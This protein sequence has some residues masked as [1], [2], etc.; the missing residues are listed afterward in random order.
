MQNITELR[1]QLASTHAK[2]LDGSMDLKTAKEL[3]NV[4]GKMIKSLSVELEYNKYLGL[5]KVIPFAT[6]GNENLDKK[7]M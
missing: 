2:I 3:T 1:D 6:T 4:A 5:K 7:R